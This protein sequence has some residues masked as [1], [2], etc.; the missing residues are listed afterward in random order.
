MRWAWDALNLRARPLRGV[1][2][3]RPRKTLSVRMNVSS[4]T[5]P[6]RRDRQCAESLARTRAG[7]GS[8]AKRFGLTPPSIDARRRHGRGGL[9]GP[10]RKLCDRRVAASRLAPPSEFD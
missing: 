10:H 4:Y 8:R 1:I 5:S 3:L 7:V 2:A 6:P 9:A